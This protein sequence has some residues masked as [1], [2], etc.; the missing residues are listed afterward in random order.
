MGVNTVI[1]NCAIVNPHGIVHGGLAIDKGKIVA[2]AQDQDLPVAERTIDVKGNFVIPG[3]VDAHVHL[4]WPPGVELIQNIRTETQ[5]S[6][7]SGVTTVIHLLAPADDILKKAKEFVDVYEK[8]AFV[9]LALSARIY[10]RE[11]IEQIQQLADYGIHGFKLLLPYKGTEA[12]WKG[13]VGGIDD[14]IVFLTLEEIARLFNQGYRVFAR[15]HCEN[16]EIFF[17]LKEKYLEQ[18]KEP[19]S[20]DEVRPRYCEEEAMR[21]MIYLSNITR[22]PLYIVHLSIGEG[23]GLVTED[24]GENRK[25]MAE[26][27]VQYLTLNRNNT[28]KVLCK[29]NPP[30]RDQEDNEKLWEG[31][32]NG[33]ISVV[34]T[35]HAP[36]PRELKTN[37]WDA[38]PGIPGIETFLPLMLSEGVNKGRISLEKMVEVCCYNPARIFGLL[39]Y[40]GWISIGSDADL[41]VI[42][43][44]KE[45]VVDEGSLYSASHLSPFA[46]WKLKGWPV[47]VMLRGEVVAEN[48][49]V[50]GVPG[51][52]RYVE[53]P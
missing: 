38:L 3:I 13:R 42:D 14:G 33:A 5:A 51:F 45:E 4:E 52:G 32:R 17:K 41:V 35:D 6:A 40:K 7:S 31:I 8:N 10:T 29:A 44:N 27:C 20:W 28:D 50:T 39:P 15:V 18:N 11:D 9:D 21:R 19:S 47:L 26:T 23:V 2:I 22:C 53:T 36:V 16:V 30:V 24:K 48:R 34:A 46:G 1:R 37:L 25:I 43:L 49:K 12:V